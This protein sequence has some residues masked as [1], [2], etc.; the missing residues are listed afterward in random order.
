MR[1]QSVNPVEARASTARVLVMGILNVTPDS[2]SDGGTFFDPGFAVR[3]GEQMAAQGAD[4]IDIGGEST[5]PG[6]ESVPEHEELR[7]VVPVVRQ[8]ARRVRAALSVDTS[9][10]TVAEHAIA[11]GA[12]IINDVTA[13]RGSPRMAHVIAR[14]GAS[15]I[16]MHMRGT[17]K[18]MQQRPRYHHVVDEI[19]RWLV[20]A[21]ARAELAG[22]ARERIFIDP[23]LGFGKTVR[24]NLALLQHLGQL[25]D[26]GF[27]VV[28]GPSRK[29]FLGALTG[30]ELHDRLGGTLA[31][32]AQAFRCGGRIVR[33]HDVK[34]AVEML[35]VLEYLEQ[36]DATRR[37]H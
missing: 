7:R 19:T 22:I 11:V 1:T 32:V 15:V 4:L 26:T 9:K 25:V 5:R 8:L 18:T 23:G 28:I 16:L 36:G 35:R 21:A 14:T 24:H 29:S 27:P 31:C 20:D 13:M 34:P 2:F 30:A 3:Q 37:Q 12:T 17:P 6:A 10:A 33:V